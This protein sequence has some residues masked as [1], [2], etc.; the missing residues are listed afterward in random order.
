MRRYVI[1]AAT[2]ATMMLTGCS[3]AKMIKMAKEQQVT[4]VP[5][6]LEVHND[7]AKFEVSALLPLKMLKPNKVY[8]I[9]LYYQAGD[10]KLPL[11]DLEFKTIDYPNNATEQPKLARTISF[12]YKPELKKGKLMMGGTA[13]NATGSKKKSL[14]IDL[15]IAEGL[16]TTSELVKPVYPVVYA[17]HGYNNKEELVPSNVDFF[18][19][20]GKSDLRVTE[21]KGKNG[22]YFEKFIAAKNVTRVVT[23]TGSHSPEGAELVNSKLSEDRSKVIEKY[24]REMAKKYNYA[25]K[26]DSIS[27]V[28]KAVVQDW[29]AFRSLLA[30]NTK[31]S[32]ADKAAINAVIDGGMGTFVEKEKEIQKLPVYK[33]LLKEIY[34]VL[35]TAKT[36]ILS[37]KK[38]KSDA[39]IS[40]IAHKIVTETA[41]DKADTLTEQELLYSASL[42]PDLNERAAI[43]A[44]ASKK[45][46]SWQSHTNLGAVYLE[47]SLKNSDPNASKELLEKAVNQFQIANAKIDKPETYLNLGTA[48]LLK[49]ETVKALEALNNCA[50]L[51]S[52]A[53]LKK[54]LN[55]IKGALEVKTAKY[56]D[57]NLSLENSTDNA[58]NKYN[59]GLALLLNRD[60]E[61]AK[62]AIDESIIQDPSNA[63][64]FYVAA[65]IAARQQ[66]LDFLAQRL[67]NAAKLDD[68]LKARAVEDLEFKAYWSND[69][70]KNA[71]R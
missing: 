67:A 28:T 26:I 13:S 6:P 61:N 55:S 11:G 36:E 9:N 70:F 24:Y 38:K 54:T 37:A 50:R 14:P 59:K 19:E 25:K 47:Q 5:S 69:S 23:I 7:S 12:S 56:R 15:E 58:I 39:Q 20:K 64:A 62:K 3:L 8:T 16:I 57:A 60:Y 40:I 52:D 42:T 49:G 45:V 21:K 10:Q 63:Q 27:F 4:V 66:N 48:L 53:D 18:F 68:K 44:A 1:S 30:A 35:R 34:P 41:T 32:D 71:L 33:T 22:Q 31:I 43:Y 51:T 29:T 46:D 65:V 17:D 2:L